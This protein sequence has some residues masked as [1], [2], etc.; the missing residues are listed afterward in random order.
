M[1][2]ATLTDLSNLGDGNPQRIAR[3]RKHHGMEVAVADHG[4]VR[5]GGQRVVVRGV[6]LCRHGIPGGGDVF[7]QRSMDL[8]HDPKRQGVLHRFGPARLE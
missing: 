2:H 4:L 7:A 5:Y 8:R 3:N 6:Q 1:R